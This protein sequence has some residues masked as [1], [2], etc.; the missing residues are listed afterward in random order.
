MQGFD[1]RFSDFPDYILGITHEIWEERGVDTLNQY[2]A[3]D[4]V[5]RSPASI[6]TGNATVI[7]ATHKTLQEF[8]DR[9]LL[10]EDV[11]WCGSPETGL[12]SSHR[13]LS[14]ATHIND[15]IY[16]PATGT[17]LIYRV[18]ADC[19]A[20][21]NVI[22]D[23]WLIRDQA[24]IV[25]QLGIHPREFVQHQLETK[26][27][28]APTPFTPDNDVAGPYTGRGNDNE[29]GKRLAKTLQRLHARDG[30][31]ITDTYDRAAQLEYPGYVH[32]HGYAGSS[33]FWTSLFT[34]FPDAQFTIDHQIGRNDVNMPARAAV[35]WSL[36]GSHKGD[37]YFG[38]PTGAEV[39]I[40]GMTH[41]EFGSLGRAPVKLRR[42]Y[43][44]F[45]ET[46]VWMQILK[47]V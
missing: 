29:W 44:L 20:K 34:A 28:A 47:Q 21:N 19:H 31:V 37:G 3:P 38:A 30:S 40:M 41:A 17:K 43:T 23:E 16:G 1:Q 12:L 26:G 33:A 18:I 7:D 4:I 25:R 36:Q 11:I 15:G 27:A 45:D 13:I 42:E 22:D 24:A 10:G 35:R 8:P 2:Y 5:V 9:E 46:A 32:A 39:Y 6:S 14:T